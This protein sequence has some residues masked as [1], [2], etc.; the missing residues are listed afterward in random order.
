MHSAMVSGIA[1]KLSKIISTL[2]LTLKPAHV[3]K[4]DKY[5]A[6]PLTHNLRMSPHATRFFRCTYLDLFKD[7]CWYLRTL[8]MFYL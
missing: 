2:G 7:L 5:S 4:E 1:R 6:S 3:K 8:G